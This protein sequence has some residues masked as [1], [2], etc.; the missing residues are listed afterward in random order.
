MGRTGSAILPQV[1]QLA[2]HRHYAHCVVSVKCIEFHDPR[3][4]SLLERFKRTPPALVRKQ[5][6]HLRKAKPCPNQSRYHQLEGALEKS[7][8]REFWMEY[9]PH[10]EI[11]G[12]GPPE[13]AQITEE[14]AESEFTSWWLL[15]PHHRPL[16]TVDI[17]RT[18]AVP[19]RA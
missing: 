5:R 12:N 3:S 1:G 16:S 7:A 14:E 19:S 11:H 15:Q 18:H 4:G 9:F 13:F 6:R 17:C 8:D 2:K 10:A